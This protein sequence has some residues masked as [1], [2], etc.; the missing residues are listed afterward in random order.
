[1]KQA[2]DL[3]TRD[4]QAV[5]A[6]HA[7]EYGITLPG[8]VGF[9]RP[10][11]RRNLTLAMDAQ[12]TLVTTASSGIPA[13]LTTLIDPEILQILTAKNVAA[14]IFGEVKKGSFVDATI[15]F[16]VVEH[17]GEV[18]SYGDF[19]ENGRSDLNSNYPNRESYLY[20]TVIEYGDLELERAGLAKINVA[21]E[22]K[23]SA[24]MTLNKFQNLT[25]FFG[26]SGIQNYGLLNDPSLSA[27]IGPSTKAGGGTKWF[28]GN[29][30]NA[31]GP[32]VYN[33]IQALVTTLIS[34]SAGLID[35]QSGM[36]LALSPK[37]AGALNFTNQFDNNVKKL[38]E[39]NYPNMRFAT[40]V[41]YGAVTAQNPQGSAGGE[42]VQLIA[43]EV[44]G[45]KTGYCAFN[46]KLR[47]GP[48]I[49]GLSSYKQKMAQGTWGAVIRQAF[50]IAQMIGV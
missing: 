20:Q 27:P 44:E 16:P 34:Q 21:D 28:N 48:V 41:Q 2:Y 37:S 8:C 9:S 26:V 30:P 38:L 32:E 10:E 11:W 25:Y 5:L 42:L 22:K 3:S 33:D 24:I 1:M 40:A 15:M 7:S 46:E 50:A 4:Q 39:T 35:A 45:Q 14:E 13:F 47:G 12:P 36:T 49:R 18:S 6:L 19:N 31:T 17:T 43:D 29:A 23:R